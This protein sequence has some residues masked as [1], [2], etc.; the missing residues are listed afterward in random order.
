MWDYEKKGQT[1]FSGVVSVLW[2]W[3]VFDL[4][5]LI[6]STCSYIIWLD[7]LLRFAIIPRLFAE[8]KKVQTLY[9]ILMSHAC[10]ISIVFFSA[11][12][13]QIMFCTKSF[14]HIW[15]CISLNLM[16]LKINF[17]SRKFNSWIIENIELL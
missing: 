10:I 2:N 5:C 7:F 3:V 9:E 1:V 15:K 13:L 8:I 4:C 16:I 11:R 14:V 6:G 12:N 17:V